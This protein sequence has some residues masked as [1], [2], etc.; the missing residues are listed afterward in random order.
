MK[1]RG[2]VTARTLP[3]HLA[4]AGGHRKHMDRYLHCPASRPYQLVSGV[5]V[6]MEKPS[7]TLE[8]AMAA[9]GSRQHRDKRSSPS[10]RVA[11]GDRDTHWQANKCGIGKVRGMDREFDCP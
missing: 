5:L 8:P 2:H 6:F 3:R 10:Q 1:K 9:N 7:F 11:V 4:A